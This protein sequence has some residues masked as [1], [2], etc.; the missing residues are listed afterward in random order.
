MKIYTKTGDKGS[1]SLVGG[2]RVAKNSSRLNAYGTVDELNSHLGLLRSKLPD[3]EEKEIIL[4]IQNTLFNLGAYLA[5]D[6]EHLQ[7]VENL[8][9]SDHDIE[10]LE[11]LI[12]KMDNQLEKIKKFIVYGED[13]LSAICHI[14][15]A[16]SRRAEREIL[17]VNQEFTIENNCIAYI[18]RLSDFLF[19]FARYLTKMN[20]GK[21]FFWKK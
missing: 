12:D 20:N 13:E 2:N 3:G 10:I 16:V 18:N 8:K 9:I 19:T 6:E 14:A 4:N 1:T 5:T 11:S 7:L 15:R 17:T 21:D